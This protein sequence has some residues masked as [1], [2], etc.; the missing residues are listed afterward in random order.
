MDSEY[1]FYGQSGQLRW[2]EPEMLNGCRFMS[3]FPFW[4]KWCKCE[5]EVFFRST[6]LQKWSR[7]GFVSCRKL[8]PAW[9]KPS[10]QVTTINCT[11]L[12]SNY[13]DFIKLK[14]YQLPQS[15][16]LQDSSAC[17]DVLKVNETVVKSAGDR[18]TEFATCT[19]TPIG[20][21]NVQYGKYWKPIF[22]SIHCLN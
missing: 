14:H 9:M 5:S 3:V 22:H 12:A 20:Q 8:G 2:T 21:R 10:T 17:R 6:F 7:S 16:E 18:G 19:V 1:I 11:L 15:P 13:V 4:T